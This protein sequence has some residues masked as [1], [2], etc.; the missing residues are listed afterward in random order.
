MWLLIQNYV[1]SDPELIRDPDLARYPDLAPDLAR[2]PDLAPDLAGDPDLI[3]MGSS[4]GFSE[5]GYLTFI[6]ILGYR[7]GANIH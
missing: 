4:R 7:S 6:W 1:D 2:D 3:Q 5:R